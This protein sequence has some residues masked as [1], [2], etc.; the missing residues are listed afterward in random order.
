MWKRMEELERSRT[1]GITVRTARWGKIG[2]DWSTFG[3]PNLE[4]VQPR[5]TPYAPV[6]YLVLR[7]YCFKTSLLVCY[8]IGGTL[9]HSTQRVSACETRYCSQPRVSPRLTVLRV[10]ILKTRRICFFADSFTRYT[11]ES[12]CIKCRSH[13]HWMD[14]RYS[15][16]FKRWP[17]LQWILHFCGQ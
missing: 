14:I 11:A 15:L 6:D 10:E 5:A 17:V 2:T 8:A 7:R 9:E 1:A 3:F 4:I 12:Y 16:Q 13:C